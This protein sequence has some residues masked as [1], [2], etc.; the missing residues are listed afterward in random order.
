MGKSINQSGGRAEEIKRNRPEVIFYEFSLAEISV[1]DDIVQAA[2]TW[3]MGFF[4]PSIRK[5]SI[6]CVLK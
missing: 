1:E 4:C 2:S 3:Q 6:K 5:A